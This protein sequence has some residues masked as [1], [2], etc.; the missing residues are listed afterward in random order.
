MPWK[1]SGVVE[2]RQRFLREYEAGE[3][4]M[5][6]LC[7]AYGISRPTG[8]EL[9]HRYGNEGA[10]GL[11]ERSRAPA[12]HPNQ[13]PPEIEEQVLAR[14]R[15][16]MR[17]GPRK[18]KACLERKQPRE[19]WPAASGSD[20]AL[21]PGCVPLV[22]PR[23]RFHTDARAR[24]PSAARSRTPDTARSSS[25]LPLHTLGETSA[26]VPPL[27]SLSKACF[28]STRPAQRIKTVNYV[29]GLFCKVCARSVPGLAVSLKRYP[30]TKPEYFRNL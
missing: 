7:R 15:A 26:V 8:Y 2:Q 18:L 19:N 22:P 6:E 23:L 11:E 20:A 12:R 28:A 3:W 10:A 24:T 16:H 25:T 21:A 4:T 13:T 14:R 17:W 27:R 5:T 29:P 30:D 9:W 1:V